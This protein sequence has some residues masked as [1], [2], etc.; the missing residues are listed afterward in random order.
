M[1]I[2][3][4]MVKFAEWLDSELDKRGWTRAELARRAGVNQSTISMAYSGQR[5][6]GVDL[7]VAIARGF[8]DISIETVFR[9]SGLLPPN[10]D[11]DPLVKEAA[12][13][14]GLLS[15]SGKQQVLDYIRFLIQ[16]EE[17]RGKKSG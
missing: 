7:A 5:N 17:S 10:H 2:I 16:A 6:V 15:E 11:G 3:F 9:M 1:T 14:I 12:Y 4:T 13:L 8:G